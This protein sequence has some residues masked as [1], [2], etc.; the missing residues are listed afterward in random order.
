MDCLLWKKKTSYIYS[1]SVTA[2]LYT[3][4]CYTSLRCIEPNL[5]TKLS[6]FQCVNNA[7]CSA[8]ISLSQINI[9][10]ADALALFA[11]VHQQTRC[12]LR[13]V[14]KSSATFPSFLTVYT[15]SH[16]SNS[17]P[18]RSHFSKTPKKHQYHASEPCCVTSI[19]SQ[20][21]WFQK[22]NPCHAKLI[23]FFVYLLFIHLYISDV[24]SKGPH[25]MK[26][27]YS[28][29]SIKIHLRI[30]SIKQCVFQEN[31]SKNAVHLNWQSV[32]KSSALVAHYHVYMAYIWELGSTSAQKMAWCY[33][34]SR[35][36]AIIWTNVDIPCHSLSYT[37]DAFLLTWMD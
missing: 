4:S 26:I 19:P 27:T 28:N 10:P 23:H 34:A 9:M 32:W 30:F 15:T 33:Q 35:H 22:L 6:W 21:N 24:L 14:G 31:M 2:V 1:T 3:I 29:I 7:Q 18:Q 25:M 36:Q 17:C 20:Q 5:F 11:P 13:A 8:I 16:I 12:W 37:W